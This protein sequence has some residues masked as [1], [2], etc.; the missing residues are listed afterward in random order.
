MYN[1]FWLT[2]DRQQRLAQKCSVSPPALSAMGWTVRLLSGLLLLALVLLLSACPGPLIRPCAMPPPVL[3][4]AL[5]E[6]LPLV[7]YSLTAKETTS[8]RQQKLD[9]MRLTLKPATMQ[10]GAN[11]QN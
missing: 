9:A 11:S 7:D 8:K 3:E 6:P 5:T 1:R 10:S 2:N 4:P